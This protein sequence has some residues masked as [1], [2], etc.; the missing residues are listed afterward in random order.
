[1]CLFVPSLECGKP[2]NTAVY[3]SVYII[4]EFSDTLG[5]RGKNVYGNR[6]NSKV[7]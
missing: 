5:R 6:K 7:W 3:W 4:P 1:M 2:T